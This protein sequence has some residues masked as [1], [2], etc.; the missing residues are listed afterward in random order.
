MGNF[1]RWG[2]QKGEV[3]RMC[4]WVRGDGNRMHAWLG[5]LWGV[6]VGKGFSCPV[7]LSLPF[8]PRF[9]SDFGFIFLPELVS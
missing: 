8:F 7:V 2:E 3:T 1:G 4:Y 9:L 6:D 5:F